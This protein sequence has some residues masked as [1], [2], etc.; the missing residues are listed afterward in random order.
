[1]TVNTDPNDEFFNPFESLDIIF[2]KMT[3]ST[4]TNSALKVHCKVDS[5]QHCF[6]QQRDSG[7]YVRDLWVNHLVSNEFVLHIL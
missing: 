7:Y 1:M 4:L 6:H 3:Q 5:I 2:F